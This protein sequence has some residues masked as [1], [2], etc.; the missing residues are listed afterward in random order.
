[1]YL[2]A[3]GFSH[4]RRRSNTYSGPRRRSISPPTCPTRQRLMSASPPPSLPILTEQGGGKE[5]RG[6]GMVAET[7]SDGFPRPPRPPPPARARSL[8]RGR[9]DCPVPVTL[10]PILGKPIPFQEASSKCG[11]NRTETS[12]S[13]ILRALKM[14]ALHYKVGD[15]DCTCQLQES[16]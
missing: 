16:Y 15:I 1:M 11:E 7:N 14:S 9:S 8:P 13:L 10:L 4:E 3:T 12:S 6:R 2:I 5:E